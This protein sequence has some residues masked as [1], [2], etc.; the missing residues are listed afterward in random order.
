MKLSKKPKVYK[1]YCNR[2]KAMLHYRKDIER[3]IKVYELVIDYK[4]VMNL[5][6]E[7][8]AYCEIG[9]SADLK[10]LSRSAIRKAINDTLC[11]DLTDDDE[12]FINGEWIQVYI[13]ENVEGLPDF[14]G[15]YEVEYF[16]QVYPKN[17]AIDLEKSIK[18][19]L[20]K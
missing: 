20:L 5:E 15:A 14:N 13:R 6:T 7:K 2:K 1:N 17:G 10:E 4:E 19:G 9:I 3:M 8:R 11:S 18:E 12:L 16:M